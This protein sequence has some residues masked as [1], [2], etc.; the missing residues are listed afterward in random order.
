MIAIINYGLGNLGSILN[1]LR[2]IG[3]EAEIIS[4]VDKIAKAEKIILPGVGAF[5]TAMEKLESTELK[6]VLE[7]KALKEKIPLLGICLGMQILGKGSEEGK[8]DGLGWISSFS[9]KFNVNQGLKVPHMSWNTVCIHKS[10]TLFKGIETDP[11]FY[12]SHSYYV[13][14][15][16]DN[17]VAGTT[18]YGIT[19][20]SVIT[21]DNIFGTQF[22]PEKSHK[23]G[24]KLL[25]NFAEL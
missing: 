4:D 15:D 18:N 9:H 24:M 5:D 11:S 2:K 20:H 13:V 12:F 21:K 22:H 14:A 1:M 25:Q 6:D 3:T 23:Y 16:S 8:K 10:H 7:I 19:F 17:D